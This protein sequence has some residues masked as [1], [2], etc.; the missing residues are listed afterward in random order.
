MPERSVAPLGQDAVVFGL[1]AA[2]GLGLAARLQLLQRELAH[3]VHRIRVSYFQGPA[4]EVAL[5]L[6][7]AGPNEV[8]RIFNTDEFKPPPGTETLPPR[9]DHSALSVTMG[10]SRAARLAG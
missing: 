9:D 2:H 8:L 7:V 4:D 10:S 5:V 1:P 3:G 6:K